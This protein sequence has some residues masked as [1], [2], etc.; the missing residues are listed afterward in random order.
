M[1]ARTHLHLIY[2]SSFLAGNKEN[3][4]FWFVDIIFQALFG[5][6]LSKKCPFT[7]VLQNFA[8]NDP[9]K[10]PISRN[11]K[12][13]KNKF[14]LN[15]KMP[16]SCQKRRNMDKMETSFIVEKQT[17]RFPKSLDFLYIS[18]ITV[19]LLIQCASNLVRN[20]QAIIQ[21]WIFSELVTKF[22]NQV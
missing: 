8:Q 18:R 1:N 2:I 19:I 13:S 3:L 7:D 6:I 22:E 15:L 20:F 10:S 5:V 12:N 21:S 14:S 11:I 16:V 9:E 17:F 4:F